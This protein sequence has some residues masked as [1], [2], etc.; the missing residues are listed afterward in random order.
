MARDTDSGAGMI[1]VP[2]TMIGQ[3]FAYAV[4]GGA[5]ALLHSVLYWVMADLI[6]IDPYIANT[7]AAVIVG[8][9]G[10]VLHSRWTFGHT[11]QSGGGL[12][13]QVRYVIVSLLCYLLNNFWV[14]LFVGQMALSV[15]LSIAPMV[16]VTPWLAFALNRFWTFA[17]LESG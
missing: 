11:D 14:W 15:T 8:V 5:M 7:L 10:Y 13:A 2:K 16:L 3:I 17:H 9:T 1:R 4:G 6:A 12:K